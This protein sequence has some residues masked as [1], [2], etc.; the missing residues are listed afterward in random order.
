[1]LIQ[2]KKYRLAA[3]AI[4]AFLL[5]INCPVSQVQSEPVQRDTLEFVESVP[6]ATTLDLP[7]IR[8]TFEVWKELIG[9]A[10]F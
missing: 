2:L 9:Q 10:R 8:N 7:E 3:I 1:M 6:V 5:L 4:L